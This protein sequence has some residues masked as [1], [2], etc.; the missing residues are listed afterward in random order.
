MEGNNQRKTCEERI[1]QELKSR[2]EQFLPDVQTWSRKECRKWLKLE[3]VEPSET[4]IQELRLRVQETIR[5]RAGEQVLGLE[6][7]SVFRL[8]LSWGG[9]ADYFELN[10]S[11]MACCWTGGRYL[12]QDWFDGAERPLSADQAEQLAEVFGI[13]PDG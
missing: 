1:E 11:E 8:C 4:E 7:I 13:Y 3:G 2:L 10:W 9:P 5:E 6:T 12:F